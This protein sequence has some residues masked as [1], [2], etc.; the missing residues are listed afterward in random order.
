MILHAK[1]TYYGNGHVLGARLCLP[2]KLGLE[3]FK[4]LKL[5]YKGALHEVNTATLSD[6]NGYKIYAPASL[7]ADA[8]AGE[9]PKRAALIEVRGVD[10]IEVLRLG[11]LCKI[12]GGFTLEDDQLCWSHRIP[13]PGR[14][15]R[16]GREL[17]DGAKLCDDCLDRYVRATLG[18]GSG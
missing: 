4:K 11:W 2:R 12:C 5:L 17:V 16:C 15:R 13:Q 8:L 14:C 7:V 9:V 3:I 10:L 18:W 6:N 1:I